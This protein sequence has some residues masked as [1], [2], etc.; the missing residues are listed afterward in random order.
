MGTV[1]SGLLSYSHTL[2]GI[3]R[4]SRSA[5]P[6]GNHLQFDRYRRAYFGI[7]LYLYF[8]SWFSLCMEKGGTGMEVKNIKIKIFD[9]FLAIKNTQRSHKEHKSPSHLRAKTAYSLPLHPR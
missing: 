3:R 2:F 6:V 1:Q 4:G 8:G 9:S 7:V 5:L